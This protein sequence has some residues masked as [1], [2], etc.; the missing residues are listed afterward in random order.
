MAAFLEQLYLQAIG[1]TVFVGALG[2]ALWSQAYRWRQLAASYPSRA[3]RRALAVRPIES[4]VATGG[5]PGW[6]SYHGVRV[7]VTEDGLSLRLFW[8]FA[9][10]S[11][12][13][14]LPFAE[15]TVR[16]TRWYLNTT[17][18]AI[19]MASTPGVDLIV[20]ED[21]LSWIREHAGDRLVG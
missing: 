19:R 21:V 2:W 11:P 8:L 4:F 17:S 1:L 7:E 9:A 18:F 10:F 15:M 20:S 12:P 3:T 5:A 13:L 6:T 16:P 14:F